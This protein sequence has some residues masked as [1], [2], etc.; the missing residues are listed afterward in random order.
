MTVTALVHRRR[1]T[2]RPTEIDADVV[3]HPV[4][5]SID[6]RSAPFRS[7]ELGGSVV[8]SARCAGDV[9]RM[10]RIGG[11]ADLT[12]AELRIHW[13]GGGPGYWG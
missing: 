10:C 4:V 7:V 1:A 13:R 8:G 6:G 9:E 5:H 3:I 12:A 2:R 11:I